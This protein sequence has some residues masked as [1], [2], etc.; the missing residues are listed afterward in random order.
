MQ[1]IAHSRSYH[2]AMNNAIDKFYLDGID[3]KDITEDF[4]REA[5]ITG[6]RCDNTDL[7]RKATEKKLIHGSFYGYSSPLEFAIKEMASNEVIEILVESG[8][9]LYKPRHDLTPFNGSPQELAEMWMKTNGKTKEEALGVIPMITQ[10][11]H[12]L[13]V[14]ENLKSN[15]LLI[16]LMHHQKFCQLHL[17][18]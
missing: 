12:D 6:I 8:Y 17:L 7:V 1:K 4:I 13:E 3:S 10:R 14:D 18:P 15:E 16:Q 5:L 2:R 11:I 9:E